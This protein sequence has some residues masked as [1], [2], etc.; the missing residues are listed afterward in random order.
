[1]TGSEGNSEGRVEAQIWPYCLD[2]SPIL[3]DMFEQQPNSVSE[4]LGVPIECVALPRLDLKAFRAKPKKRALGEDQSFLDK[5]WEKRAII[6][7]LTLQPRAVE[8][9]P[10]EERDSVREPV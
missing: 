1:I 5:D 3:A 6:P 4:L 9:S 8:D 10:S 2:E 7:P